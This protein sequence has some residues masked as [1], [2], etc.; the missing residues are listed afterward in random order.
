MPRVFFYNGQ[1]I[2]DGAGALTAAAKNLP[3]A[4]DTSGIVNTPEAAQTA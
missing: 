4:A 2:I 3:A 1:L